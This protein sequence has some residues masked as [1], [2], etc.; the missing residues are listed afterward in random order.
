[1]QSI[2]G[3]V[4]GGGRL[5]VLVSIGATALFGCSGTDG[6]SLFGAATP[7]SPGTQSP[8]PAGDQFLD[9]GTPSSNAP[10]SCSP[11][12]MGGWQATWTAPEAFAQNVCSASQ[13]AGF[14]SACLA[15]PVDPAACTQFAQANAACSACLDTKDGDPAL[16]PVVWHLG[17]TYYTVNVAGCIARERGDVTATGCGAVYGET[18][19][20][21]EQACNA[22]FTTASPSFDQFATCEGEAASTVCKGLHDSIPPACGNLNTGAAAT[23]FPGKGATAEDAYTLVAPK[24]CGAG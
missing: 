19:E 22:C 2:F 24:F 23:C 15:S 8:V 11:A 7:P 4:F 18:V 10:T 13:I 12:A 14:Y 6:Q 17:R 21:Q 20:C 16:G 1:M 5:A 3:G 9:A